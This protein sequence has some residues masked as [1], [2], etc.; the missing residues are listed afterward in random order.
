[1]DRKE[2]IMSL[3]MIVLNCHQASSSWHRLGMEAYM[4]IV[5][6]MTDVEGINLS[7]YGTYKTERG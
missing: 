2:N 3:E 4:S 7:Q 1:M 6:E 5:T